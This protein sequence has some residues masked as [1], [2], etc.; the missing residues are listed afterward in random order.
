MASDTGAYTRVERVIAATGASVRLSRSSSGA[1]A[2]TALA[3]GQALAVIDVDAHPAVVYVDATNPVL[4]TQAEL[5]IG[6]VLESISGPV[7]IPTPAFSVRRLY[8][9]GLTTPPFMVTGLIG[10]ILTM[11]VVMMSALSVARERERGTLEGL[12]A[13]QVTPG[14]LWMGK[15]APYVVLGLVQAAF[16]LAVARFLFH[17]VPSARCCYL[18]SAR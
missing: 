18:G 8:N 9:P 2:Q 15:L 11:S 13:A 16:V 3:R 12:L 14:E 6:R 1:A 7:E 4:A 5:M 10:V 17:I